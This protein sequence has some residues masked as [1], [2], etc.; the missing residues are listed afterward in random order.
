[1]HHQKKSINKV[2]EE[3]SIKQGSAEMIKSYQKA[4]DTIMKSLTAKEIQEAKALAKEWNERQ[5]PQDVQSETTEKKGC[6]YAEEFAKEMWK[7][8]GAR[9]VVMAAWEDADGEMIVGA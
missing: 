4:I 1:M 8:C 9:V 5:P 2:L 7:W 3:A 6:K